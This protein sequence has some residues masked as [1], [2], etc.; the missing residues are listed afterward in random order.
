MRSSTPTDTPS[1]PVEK[2]RTDLREFASLTAI[3]SVEYP[4][5]GCAR[6][7]V[8]V[9]AWPETAERIACPVCRGTGTCRGRTFA[10]GQ[11]AHHCPLC[12]G[13]GIVGPEMFT[14]VETLRTQMQRVADA[15]QAGDADR[16]GAEARVAGRIAQ[17]MLTRK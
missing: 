2:S 12:D 17:R 9:N 1:H 5:T 7:I 6:L 4:K 8:E 15:M 16:A 14:S 10:R 11:R 3:D 13:I